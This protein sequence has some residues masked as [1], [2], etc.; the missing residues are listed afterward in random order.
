ML[1]KFLLYNLCSAYLLLKQ[2]GCAPKT[3]LVLI[4]ARYWAHHSSLQASDREPELVKLG[5]TQGVKWETGCV[6]PKHINI[7]LNWTHYNATISLMTQCTIHFLFLSILLF[8]IH[9][10]IHSTDLTYYSFS[11]W[12]LQLAESYCDVAYRCN[13]LMLLFSLMT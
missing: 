12:P 3:K 1:F 10:T 2:D 6:N 8:Q 13:W 11:Y 9:S 4:G 5:T 7:K